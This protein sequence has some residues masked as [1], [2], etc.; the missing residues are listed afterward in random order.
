MP[1]TA[2]GYAIEGLNAL[3]ALLASNSRAK[4][5]AEFIRDRMLAMQAEN[6]DPSPEERAE[7]DALIK[8]ELAQLN[9]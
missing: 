5:T 9:A 1:V 4:A 6:R 7:L 2:I 8:A 3:I